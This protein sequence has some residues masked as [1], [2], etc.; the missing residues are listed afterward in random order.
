MTVSVVSIDPAPSKKS[1]VCYGDGFSEKDAGELR[2]LLDRFAQA[3]PDTLICW[4]APLTGPRDAERA[5]QTNKDFS[6]RRLESFFSRQDGLKAPKG[7]S[8]LPYSGCPHWAI[9]RSLLGLPRIGPYD[10]RYEDLPFHLVPGERR[11][12]DPRPSVVEIH[13]AVAAWLWCKDEKDA[14]QDN[15]GW[16][17]KPKKNSG[18]RE[19]MWRVIRRRTRSVA[20]QDPLSGDD[21]DFD[22]AVGYLLGVLYLRDRE[23]PK[24]RRKVILLGDREKGSFL[25]PNVDGLLDRWSGFLAK[26]GSSARPRP[27]STEIREGPRPTA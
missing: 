18:I 24:P 9:T 12:G 23:K 17:Y 22:A 6:Q 15:D 7:I 8:V 2:V 3:G 1:T 16:L 20:C 21:D 10:A 13:P 26:I 25:V 5:G 4:D 27:A 14:P 11:E 19:W